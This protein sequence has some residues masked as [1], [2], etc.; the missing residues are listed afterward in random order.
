MKY[1]YDGLEFDSRE[2]ALRYIRLNIPNSDIVE[3][4]LE[5][6]D[7]LYICNALN[8]HVYYK[9]KE[10]LINQFGE[11]CAEQEDAYERKAIYL[12]KGILQHYETS[13]IYYIMRPHIMEKAK[14]KLTHELSENEMSL[15]ESYDNR[16]LDLIEYIMSSCSVCDI[17]SF[18]RPKFANRIREKITN[19]LAEKIEERDDFFEDFFEDFFANLDF[20]LSDKYQES[21]EQEYEYSSWFEDSDDS[22]FN[23]EKVY[24][25]TYGKLFDIILG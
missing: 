19:A 3:Y 6:Y 23:D 22:I 14:R 24:K 18:L 16:A 20:Y 13:Y 17:Y 5:R 7:S 15:E 21:E 2:D 1:C 8:I 25:K 4:M 9:F 11:C 12:I 10:E